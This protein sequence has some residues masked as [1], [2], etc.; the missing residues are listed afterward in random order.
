MT[1]DVQA[2]FLLKPMSRKPEKTGKGRP[3]KGTQLFTSEDGA[4]MV[5]R[6]RVAL[7]FVQPESAFTS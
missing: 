5:T 7:A 1:C 2:R 6:C 3:E 4:G